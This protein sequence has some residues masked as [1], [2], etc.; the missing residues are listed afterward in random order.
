MKEEKE[1]LFFFMENS[2][3]FIPEE[4]IGRLF[5]AFYRVDNSRNRQLGGS[6]LGLY[7]VRMILEQHG[8]V[9]GAG[10]TAKGVRF[11]FRLSK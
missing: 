4:S 6:G 3:V 2:D 11:W 7:I 10:N 9:Y 1:E 8:A 5:D